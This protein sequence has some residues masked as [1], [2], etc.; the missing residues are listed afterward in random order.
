MSNLTR[1][2]EQRGTTVESASESRRRGWVLLLR[3]A[4]GR[5]SSRTRRAWPVVRAGCGRMT[6]EVLAGDLVWEGAQADGSIG[7]RIVE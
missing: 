2:G 3:N 5:R 1:D 4:D 6:G 7:G